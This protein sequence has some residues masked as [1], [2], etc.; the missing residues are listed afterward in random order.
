MKRRTMSLRPVPRGE[1]NA[2]LPLVADG[3]TAELIKPD[4]GASS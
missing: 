1:M 4:R 2:L 3:E